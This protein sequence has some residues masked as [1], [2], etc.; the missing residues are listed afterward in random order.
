MNKFPLFWILNT[1]HNRGI[2]FSSTRNKIS[3]GTFLQ[4]EIFASLCPRSCSGGGHTC[5]EL[6]PSPACPYVSLPPRVIPRYWVLFT[7]ITKHWNCLCNYVQWQ[8][9]TTC[10]CFQRGNVYLMATE[11]RSQN[12]TND[13]MIW[14]SYVF[15]AQNLLNPNQTRLLLTASAAK[16]MQVC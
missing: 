13:W 12:E 14:I 7:N 1:S 10:T 9:L 16:T 3:G 2:D 11:K 6:P 5:L 4:N 8:P 15:F